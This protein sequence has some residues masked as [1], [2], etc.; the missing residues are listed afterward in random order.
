[1]KGKFFVF[2]GVVILC[3]IGVF[4]LQAVGSLPSL[5]QWLDTQNP[6]KTPPTTITTGDAIITDI[7]QVREL[8]TT[9]YIIQ[10]VAEGGYKGSDDPNK[11]DCKSW[12]G[13]DFWTTIVVKGRVEAGLDLEQLSAKNVS[14]SDDGKSI[15]VNLPPVKIL[16]DIRHILSSNESETYVYSSCHTRNA[17]G[18]ED[19]EANLR[20]KAGDQILE[21][22]CKDG[23]L[24]HAA[25][26]ANTSIDR[27]LKLSQPGVDITV[28]SAPVPSVDE[29]KNIGILSD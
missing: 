7:N 11:A 21:S 24:I 13:G 25:K 29:C 28:V 18:W 27:F 22:A 8:T 9:V 23:I 2:I 12:F 26:D 17:K 3:I 5:N 6:F 20:A 14:F 4:V 15:T 16:T 10:Q 1:M 19:I